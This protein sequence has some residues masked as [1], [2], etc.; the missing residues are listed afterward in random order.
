MGKHRAPGRSV[1]LRDYVDTRLADLRTHY[2][3][4]LFEFNR[5]I[6][7]AQAEGERREL[8]LERETAQRNA[9]QNEWRALVEHQTAATVQR[10]EFVAA[11]KSLEGKF[12]AFQVIVGQLATGMAQS[13]GRGIGVDKM[14]AYAIGVGG[15]FLAFLSSR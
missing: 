10:P 9:G 14:L 15:L 2:D 3:A 1:D 7:A 11:I 13:T 8:R 4:R 5:A 6:V 12:D